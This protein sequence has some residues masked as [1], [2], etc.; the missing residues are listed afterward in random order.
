MDEKNEALVENEDVYETYNG[1]PIKLTFSRSLWARLIQSTDSTKNNYKMIR[2]YISSYKNVKIRESWNYITVVHQK[3]TIIKMNLTKNDVLLYLNLTDAQISKLH[4]DHKNVGSVKAFESTPIKFHID[5]NPE[6]PKKAIKLVNVVMSRFKIPRTDKVV[7]VELPAYIKHDDLIADG[8]IKVYARNM[9]TNAIYSDEESLKIYNAIRLGKIE[10]ESEEVE[11]AENDV[12][13][14]TPI[15]DNI[16]DVVTEETPE[17]VETTEPVT[18]NETE[19]D[20]ETTEETVET[21]AEEE[22]ETVENEE[23]EEETE[24]EEEV[25]TEEETPAEETEESEEEADS[26][27]TTETEVVETPT[28]EE[29]VETETVENEDVEEET[30]EDAIE[31]SESEET[32]GETEEDDETLE[33]SDDEE[34]EDEFINASATETEEDEIE[35]AIIENLGEETDI[36][37]IVKSINKIMVVSVGEILKGMR[38]ELDITEERIIKEIKEEI[39]KNKVAVAY[40]TPVYQQAPVYNTIQNSYEEEEEES[41][42]NEEEEVETPVNQQ[43]YTPY[44]SYTVPQAETEETEKEEETTEETVETPAEKEEVETKTVEKTPVAPVVKNVKD[45]VKNEP[46]IIPPPITPAEPEK[47]AEVKAEPVTEVKE[48]KQVPSALFFIIFATIALIFIG[49]CIAISL[50]V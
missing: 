33:A 40:E 25:T 30:E 48:E 17:E 37:S 27:E 2:E 49:A 8:K 34:D 38:K 6:S 18:T 35:K 15:E 13:V 50:L 16:E 47:P 4:Y 10:E 12:V 20:E 7:P 3:K 32:T 28:E 29:E 46:V 22:T 21:P 41:E 42:E 26:E 9:N 1:I 24:T 45:D 36:T 23:S 14:E 19:E 5:E 31:K 44:T 43:I 11:T 39:E